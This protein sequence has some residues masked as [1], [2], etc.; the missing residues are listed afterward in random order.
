MVEHAH[1]NAYSSHP[2]MRIRRGVENID[3]YMLENGSDN[4]FVTKHCNIGTMTLISVKVQKVTVNRH[5][6]TV[7]CRVFHILSLTSLE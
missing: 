7:N 3:V 2:H 4:M 5:L 6:F 1:G